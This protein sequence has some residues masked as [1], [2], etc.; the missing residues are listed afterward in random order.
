MY[1]CGMRDER[2]S[3]MGH[4]EWIKIGDDRYMGNGTE[5]IVFTIEY[6]GVIIISNEVLRRDFARRLASN[7]FQS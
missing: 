1:A 2:Q 4:E 3:E 7:H 5:G 6:E